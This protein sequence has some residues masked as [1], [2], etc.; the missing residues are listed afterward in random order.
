MLPHHKEYLL[1]FKEVG[2]NLPKNRE[3]MEDK[4]TVYFQIEILYVFYLDNNRYI[5]FIPHMYIKVLSTVM[6]L[7]IE[8]NAFFKA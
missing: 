3:I 2:N 8:T 1:Y 6:V 5:N 4:F 7:G